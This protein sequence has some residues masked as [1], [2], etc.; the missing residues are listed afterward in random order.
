MAWISVDQK[1]IGGKLRTL[2]KEIGCSRNEAI[3]IL[4]TLWLWGIDN[5]DMDGMIPSADKSDIAEVLRPGISED[6][7]PE[8]IVGKL[9]EC[10]W[11]D[12]QDN[13]LYLHDWGEW[14]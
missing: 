6:L 4:I 9:I 5:S 3:G 13:G 8:L 10:G 14:R 7:D 12:E 2:H 11:I 1:L